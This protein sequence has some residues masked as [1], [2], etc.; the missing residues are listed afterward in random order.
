MTPS[1]RATFVSAYS[2]LVTTVWTDPRTERRLHEDPASVL[3]DFGLD[4]PAGVTLQ[5]DRNTEFQQPDLEAQVRAW[6]QAETTGALTLA[7]PPVPELDRQELSD[8]ELAGVVGGIDTGC[9]CCCPC[10]CS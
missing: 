3:A 6:E 10:C 2:N 7:V 8:D 9:A 1:N 4:L 5:L